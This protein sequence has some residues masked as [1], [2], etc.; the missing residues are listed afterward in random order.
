MPGR[1]DPA[2]VAAFFD[3]YGDREWDRHDTPAGRASL[4]VHLDMI[5]EFVRA[6]DLVLDAGAG[7][8]RFTVE[9]ARLGARVHVGDLSP[10]QLAAHRRRVA[11]AGCEDAVTAREVLD[12]CDLSHLPD[13]RFDVVVCLGGPLSYVRDQADRALSELVRVTRP[14]GYVLVSVMSTAG[15]L[16]A[17]LPGVVEELRRYGPEHVE[18]VLRTGELHRETNGGHE[19]R[20]Y[21][22]SELERLCTRHGEVVAAAA[23]NFLTADAD[24][25]VHADLTP[26]E[27]VRVLAWERRLCREPGLLDAGTHILA[28]LRR[29]G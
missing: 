17:F 10:G 11:E 8:G 27:Q 16:R 25:A 20:M 1:F 14:G 4:A 23:A 19:M 21:R 3:A 18:A 15:A 7:P 9:L 24:R 6:G 2:H 28:A 12:I 26:D 5:T 22:W 13:G 29:P